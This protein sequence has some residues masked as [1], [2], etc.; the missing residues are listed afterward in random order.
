MQYRFNWDTRWL[1][2]WSC[3]SWVIKEKSYVM[4]MCIRTR[5][6]NSLP[7]ICNVFFHKYNIL[8]AIQ[9]LYLEP[10]SFPRSMWWI[11][12]LKYDAP[13]TCAVYWRLLCKLLCQLLCQRLYDCFDISSVSCSASLSVE[14]SL[15]YSMS[16]QQFRCR[17]NHDL[18]ILLPMNTW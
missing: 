1:N 8:C 13:M 14:C 2:K 16:C 9:H 10:Y 6:S 5:V 18:A 17:S 4:T 12:L 11:Y 3:E 7:T 15:G